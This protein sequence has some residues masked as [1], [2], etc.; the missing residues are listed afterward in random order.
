MKSRGPSRRVPPEVTMNVDG[1]VGEHAD[2]TLGAVAEGDPG[3]GHEV[4][5]GLER[6]GHVEVV[7]G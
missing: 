2:R 1:P 3:A 4:D 7:D 5:P 6:G